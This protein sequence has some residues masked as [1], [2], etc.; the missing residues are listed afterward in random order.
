MHYSLDENRR[1][2]MIT[3]KDRK[4]KTLEKQIKDNIHPGSIIRSD[5]WKSY[6]NIPDINVNPR[7]K[8]IL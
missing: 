4:Q 7:Y 8:V 5:C 1:A 6:V 2:F 3:V